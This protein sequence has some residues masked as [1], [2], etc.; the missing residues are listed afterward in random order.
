M[1]E[2]GT[3]DILLGSRGQKMVLVAQ[4]CL[5]LCDPMD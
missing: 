3:K 1:P 4:L 2:T 5:T